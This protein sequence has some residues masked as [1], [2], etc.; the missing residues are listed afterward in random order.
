MPQGCISVDIDEYVHQGKNGDYS[1]NYKEQ[2]NLCVNGDMYSFIYGTGIGQNYIE[3]SGQ[4]VKPETKIEDYVFNATVSIN[5]QQ[6]EEITLTYQDIVELFTEE[7]DS[8]IFSVMLDKYLP[9]VKRQLMER[10]KKQL[11]EK[12]ARQKKEVKRGPLIEPLIHVSQRRQGL[13]KPLPVERIQG[14]Q[15]PLPVERIQGLQ[16]SLPVEK[17]QGLQKSL[18]FERRQV[19]Q[20]PQRE[21]L[22]KIPF[23]QGRLPDTVINPE[24]GREI[25]IGGGTFKKLCDSGRYI[26]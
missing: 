19:L 26:Y 10:Q 22:T 1:L 21:E 7:R 18:P 23:N 24:T 16:K 15:K 14:L 20:K 2:R 5:Q 12:H 4:S 13:Q 9:L 17:I 3:I 6:K 11:A 25:K 8:S